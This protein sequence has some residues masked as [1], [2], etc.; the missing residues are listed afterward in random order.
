MIHQI[1]TARKSKHTSNILIAFACDDLL[2][3]GTFVLHKIGVLAVLVLPQVTAWGHKG[4]VLVY[5]RGSFLLG[6]SHDFFFQKSSLLFQPQ[7][8]LLVDS[9]KVLKLGLELW[10]QVRF[11][12]RMLCGSTHPHLLALQPCS[13]CLYSNQADGHMWNCFNSNWNEL[14]CKNTWAKQKQPH[15]QTSVF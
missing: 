3:S 11:L 9:F 8:L 5:L 2:W 12:L 4:L 10:S 14:P 7:L 6:E 13:G 15:K 1:K